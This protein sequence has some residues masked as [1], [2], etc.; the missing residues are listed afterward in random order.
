MCLRSY[1]VFL[2]VLWVLGAC[3]IVLAALVWLPF[4]AGRQCRHHRAPP[5]AGWRRPFAAVTCNQLRSAHFRSRAR[6]FIA[7]YPLIPWFAV[8]ALGYWTAPCSWKPAAAAAVAVPIGLAT[9]VA[10]LVIRAL[11][12]YGD[13]APWSPQP[14]RCSPRCRS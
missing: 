6:V 14:S 4:H 12:G 3:M 9:D 1:P 11:N 13:P 2:L 10:F 7:A 5:S 8:M